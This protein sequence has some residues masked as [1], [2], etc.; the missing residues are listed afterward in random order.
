MGDLDKFSP[1]P[2]ISQLLGMGDIRGLM[3]H[4]SDMA[5][6]N[7]NRQKEITKNLEEGKLSIRDWREQ[8]QNIMSMYAFSIN[9]TSFI[10]LN[11]IRGPLSKITS[12]IPGLSGLMEGLGEGNDEEASVRL[13]RLICITDSMTPEELNS[14]GMI[15][16]R[17]GKDG[18]PTGLRKNVR[19]VAKGSGS[20]IREVEEVLIQHRMMANMAKQMGGK[21]GMY[22]SYSLISVESAQYRCRL[23]AL[24]GMPPG[25]RGR[26]GPGPGGM[27]PSQIQAMRVS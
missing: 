3:E 19:R 10:G 8:M 23:Q 26:G 14:D 22:G 24:K 9:L 12:K 27:S 20:S 4:M 15:F 11:Y 1:E 7:P 21:N 18:V 17:V 16:M 6:Q 25:G 5:R 13:K 2:F